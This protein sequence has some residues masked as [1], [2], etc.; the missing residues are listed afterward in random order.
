MYKLVCNGMV[1]DVLKEICYVRYLP[2]QERMVITDR[3]SANGVMGSDKDTVYHLT[4]TSN[5]FPVTL[6]SV[7]VFKISQEEFDRLHTEQAFQLQR[8]ISLEEKVSGLE[9]QVEKQNSLLEQLI[10]KLNS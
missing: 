2:K 1:I 10:E 6:N 8:Q 9:A 5:T 3:Q 7:Q 4:G